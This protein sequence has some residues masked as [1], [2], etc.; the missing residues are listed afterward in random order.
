[1]YL[2]IKAHTFAFAIDTK[3]YIY[4]SMMKVVALAKK[5]F[6]ISKTFYLME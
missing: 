1:M 6:N 5:Y 2:R 3:K 4:R